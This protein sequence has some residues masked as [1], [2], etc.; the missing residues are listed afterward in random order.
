MPMYVSLAKYNADGVRGLMKD[1]GTGRR[2]AVERAVKGLGG[3]LVGFYFAFGEWDAYVISEAPDNVSVAALSLAVGSTGSVSVTTQVL[4][5]AEEMDQAVA[6]T[7][8]YKGPG[9]AGKKEK[10]GK[11]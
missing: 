10:K 4:L 9:Q 1:G 2:A 6:K 7:V 11:K 8:G 3:T 5:T